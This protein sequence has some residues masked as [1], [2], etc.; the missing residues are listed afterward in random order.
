MEI[1]RPPLLLYLPAVPESVP[2][3]RHAVVAYSVTCG[4]EAADVATATTEAVGNVVTHA[5]RG[6]DPGPVRIQAQLDETE[7][8]VTV[9]DEGVGMRPNP[10]SPGLGMGL[11]MI[12]AVT[13]EMHLDTSGT[14]LRITMRFPCPAGGDPTRPS[15]ETAGGRRAPLWRSAAERA[16]RP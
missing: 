11:S 5:Y 15:R 1:N 6:R 4:A 16:R 14:G 7:L 10:G 8:L 12:G 9:A 2:K 13:S 3:A